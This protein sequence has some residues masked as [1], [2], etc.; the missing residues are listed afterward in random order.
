MLSLLK[1][2]LLVLLYYLRTEPR[3]VRIGYVAMRDSNCTCYYKKGFPF[4]SVKITKEEEVTRAMN[5]KTKT[6]MHKT[7]TYTREYIILVLK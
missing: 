1:I 3:F 4:I 7:K 6:K 5:N 2:I